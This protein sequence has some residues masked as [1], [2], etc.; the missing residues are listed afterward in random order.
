MP[1]VNLWG[2]FAGGVGAYLSDKYQTRFWPLVLYCPLGMAGY[3]VCLAPVSARVHYFAT[4]LIAT[5]CFLC[6]GGNM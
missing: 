6:A 3:A 5:A 1:K 2:A 4:Y